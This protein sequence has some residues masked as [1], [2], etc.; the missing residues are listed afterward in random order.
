MSRALLLAGLAALLFVG[1]SGDGGTDPGPLTVFAAASLKSSLPRIDDSI[2]YHFAGSDELALQIREGA[3]A[4][5]YAAA[6]PRYALEL[7]EDNLLR[8][9]VA[10]ATNELVLIVPRDNPANIESPADLDQGTIRLVIGAQGVPV[11][12]Y[13]RTALERLGLSS[14]LEQVVSEEQ[15]VTAVVGKVVL[16]EADAGFVYATDAS[17]VSNDVRAIHLPNRAQPDIRLLIAVTTDSSHPAEAQRFVD[18]ILA[19]DGRDTL[20]DAGFGPP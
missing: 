7:A 12:D 18:Q 17:A 13:T 11:G 3:Q 5:V 8:A 15:D 16:G 19:D 2:R 20:R 6:S 4:D 14:V 1:C 10:F 9:P